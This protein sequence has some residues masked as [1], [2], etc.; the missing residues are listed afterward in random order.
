[1][2]RKDPFSGL[3]ALP[4][5]DFTKE[6]LIEFIEYW[7]NKEIEFFNKAKEIEANDKASG[8]LHIKEKT[9]AHKGAL[10]SRCSVI[11]GKKYLAEGIY[12]K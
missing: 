11:A 8:V 6:E 5:T 3:Y 10:L 9:E 7:R 4:R 2:S 1:M 12:K